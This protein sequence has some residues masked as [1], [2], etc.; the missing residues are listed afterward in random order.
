MSFGYSE[1]ELILKNINTSFEKGKKYAIVGSSG[2]GKSS[3][4]NL[5]LKSNTTYQGE[6]QFDS[7]ELRL[8]AT[9]CIYDIISYIQQNVFIFDDTIENNIKMYKDFEDSLVEEVI[10]QVGL[11]DL[12]SERG[13]AYHCGEG[14]SNLSGGEKQRLS[15][16]RGLI[17]GSNILLMDE[18]T[19]ALDNKIAYEIEK[20][21][22]DIEGLTCIVITHK[23]TADLLN[24]YDKIIVLANKTIV[25]EGDFK[26][27]MELNGIFSSFF[28][29][30]QHEEP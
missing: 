19:A 16:A 15:I 17:R 6:I 27:L 20:S 14:G 1:N 8:I 28:N 30:S 25:E 12:V 22:L 7:H 26:T 2:S 11:S 3:L 5:I 29:M 23:M 4:L 21:V 13:Q 18:G 24:Q 10:E 9:E